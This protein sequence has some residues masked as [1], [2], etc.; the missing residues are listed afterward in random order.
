MIETTDLGDGM[1][2]TDVTVSFSP[3]AEKLTDLTIGI[4]GVSTTFVGNVYLDDI[5]LSQYN[6]AADFVDITSVPQAGTVADTSK[7][8]A[9]VTLSDANATTETKALYAISYRTF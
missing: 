2:K 9:T 5:K 7:M 3:N 4:V 8:P 1:V 6:A